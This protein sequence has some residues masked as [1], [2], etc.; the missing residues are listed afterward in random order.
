MQKNIFDY[1][2]YSF[3]K[4]FSK[5]W[6]NVIWSSLLVTAASGIISFLFIALSGYWVSRNVS[7]FS[8]FQWEN[9][10]L[11]VGNVLLFV[12]VL[13][14]IILITRAWQ[15]IVIPIR[16]IDPVTH[17]DWRGD[18]AIFRTHF[19]RYMGYITWYSLLMLLLWVVFLV[20]LIVVSAIDQRLGIIFGIG[21][22]IAILYVMTLFYVAWYHVL[23][24][25]S[26]GWRMFFDSKKF[27]IWKAWVVFWKVA[28]F[29]I[30]V[31]IIASTIESTIYGLLSWDVTGGTW[32]E[33]AREIEKDTQ[34]NPL[35][36]LAK[37]F[38]IFR[39]YPIGISGSWIF[40]I[41]FFSLSSVL[42][43]AMFHIFYVRY[44]LDLRDEWEISTKK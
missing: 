28:F 31:W 26:G 3:K 6:A 4:I 44:Y 22:I 7:S 29:S 42:S 18:L 24:E 25:W 15:A 37:M 14:T 35:D 20:T 16:S 27:I 1:L 39:T 36:I 38:E 11:W 33:L 32:D 13:I 41:L 17:F 10:P 40:M 34:K 23:S 21:G 8:E 12:C 5:E 2:E 9:I 43:N 30:I 19:W